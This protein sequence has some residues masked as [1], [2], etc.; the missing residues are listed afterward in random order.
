MPTNSILMASYRG[1]NPPTNPSV[2]TEWQSQSVKTL[3]ISDSPTDRVTLITGFG[4]GI[5]G[6]IIQEPKVFYN[7]VLGNY[8]MYASTNTCQIYLTAPSPQGPWTKFGATYVNGIQTTVA[9]SVLGA[10]VGGFAGTAIHAHKYIE[11]TTIYMCFPDNTNTV[12]KVATA[13]LSAPQTFTTVQTIFTVPASASPLANNL[14]NCR[15]NK[16]NG[17]YYLFY[18]Y[19]ISAQGFQQGV[20]TS[21]TVIGTYTSIASVMESLWPTYRSGTIGF[22]GSSGGDLQAFYENGTYVGY[23][24]WG[25]TLTS[26]IY[27]HFSNDLVTWTADTYG[28]PWLR[29]VLPNEISQVADIELFQDQG[30]NYWAYWTQY[31]NV[32]AIASIG[33]SPCIEPVYIWSGVDWVPKMKIPSCAEPYPITTYNIYNASRTVLNKEKAVF[34][35]SGGALNSTLPF[36]DAGNFCEVVNYGPTGV[37]LITLVPQSG[38]SIAAAA[39]NT[40]AVGHATRLDCYTSNVWTIKAG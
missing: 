19:F 14:G 10:G 30:E 28:R 12:F 21:A 27:R 16:L 22:G 37:N 29:T 9:T 11:G 40:V 13:S 4:S 35:T 25:N 26:N 32:G 7:S 18:D 36:A 3:Q 5:E 6:V 17:V 15:I 38:D 31:Q 1:V 23:S 20:A 8:G 34:Q 33:I 24:H 2:N 39:G